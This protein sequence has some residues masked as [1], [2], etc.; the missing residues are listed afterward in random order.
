MSIAAK[1]MSNMILAVRHDVPGTSICFGDVKSV[2]TTAGMLSATVESDGGAYDDVPVLESASG[3]RVG[4]RVMMIRSGGVVVVI[5]IVKSTADPHALKVLWSN[6]GGLYMNASQSCQLSEPMSAQR[7]GVVLHWQGYVPGDG[8]KDYQ[9][10]FVFVP[11][12]FNGGRGL[13]MLLMADSRL[14]TKYVYIDDDRI[15]GNA[16][17]AAADT[18]S[19]VSIDNRYQALTEVLGV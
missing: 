17:N 8:V 1:E 15:T 6:S 14:V 16:Q 2:G 19:G 7:A 18:I 13:G 10:N 4:D 11:K 3:V 9:H 5:G 12:T